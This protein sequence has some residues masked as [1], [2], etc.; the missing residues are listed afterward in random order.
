MKKPMDKALINKIITNLKQ[1]MLLLTTPDESVANSGIRYWQEKNLLI[2][3]SL[4]F[5]FGTIVYIPSVALSIKEDLW[6]I[7][8]ADTLIYTYII[9]L[10]FFK[11][12]PYMVRASSLS[13]ISYFLG[14]ILLIVLGPFGG[15]PVWLFVFPV[16]TVLLMTLREAVMALILNGISI[17]GIGALMMIYNFEG[18]AKI[19][20][21]VNPVEKWVVSSLNFMLLNTIVVFS[22]ASVL[23]GLKLSLEQLNRARK[24][25]ALGLLAGGVAHDLNNILSAIVGFPD[26]LMMEIEE[27]HPMRPYLLAIKNSGNRAAEIIQDLLTLSRRGVS[28]REVINLNDVVTDFFN[29]PEFKTILSFHPNT[30]VNKKLQKNLPLVMGSQHHLEKTLM[31]LISNAA[32]AQSDKNGIITVSTSHCHVKKTIQSYCRVPKGEYVLL[33]VE[34]Q[35]TG[36][37][38]EDLERIFEPF[39][40]KKKMGRSGTGLGMA[41]VWGTVQ[42]H[43]GYIDVKSILDEGT[44][45]TLYFP[46]TFERRKAKNMEK[47]LNHIM[48]NKE[49]ILIVD[50][51]KSL[52][53]VITVMLKSLN[54]SPVYVQNGEES[55][56]YLQHNVADLVLLDMIMGEG[57]DGLETYRE[58]IKIH[59]EQKA[60]VLSG[61]SQSEKVDEVIRLGAS[62]YLKKPCTMKV[63]GE[64]IKEVF[65][66]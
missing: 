50:D 61:F 54:Y 31:N 59:P 57:M 64:A 38:S 17:F 16:I 56:E 41:V 40:T 48:G 30:T 49:S 62:K 1:K 26:L 60:I 20:V 47:N 4:C 23:K 6:I 10:F 7:A 33:G 12:L 45:F 35:G 24:M 21:V 28:N 8:V 52:G 39:F 13:L 43:E 42:D 44:Q 25:E 65:S 32:E 63:L 34:D 9:V 29:T 46:V 2:L 53:D 22:A 58:I 37:S 66:K 14:M 36:I 15:G 19:A 55:I 11:K 18:W 5:V 3:L 51:D 27:D